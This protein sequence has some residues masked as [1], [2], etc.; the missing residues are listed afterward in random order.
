MAFPQVAVLTAAAVLALA[1]ANA[2]YATA[3]AAPG[4]AACVPGKSETRGHS[5][6]D[7]LEIRFTE[8]TKYDDLRK[9]AI[10]EWNKIQ[11]INIAGDTATTVND[12]EFRDYT[13][14]TDGYG[15]YYE[16]RGGTAATDYI[17]LNTHAM[18]VDFGDDL[19]YRRNVIVHEL[20]HAL[21]LCHKA[22]SANSVMR[23]NASTISVPTSV[24][25]ANLKKLWGR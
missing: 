25:K 17:Y 2:P 24:D 3:A 7:D 5:A 1:T 19:R 18:E 8:A 13:S 9:Y 12:L 20:G 10:S 16:H 15:G 11:T 23:E 4:A 14:K 6:V 22:N 21:G